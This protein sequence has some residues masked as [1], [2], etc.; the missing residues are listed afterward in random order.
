MAV[1][2]GADYAGEAVEEIHSTEILK[3]RKGRC[4]H[5]FA[6]ALS[7]S[8][9]EALEVG[10]EV[11]VAI[12]AQEGRSCWRQIA[13]IHK[14]LAGMGLPLF[15]H[16]RRWPRRRLPYLDRWLNRRNPFLDP[17]CLAQPG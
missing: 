13:A 1:R 12:A 7:K 14:S 9:G 8:P 16:S 2:G 15:F 11:E 4:A 3:V 10:N 5:W 6:N 17:A